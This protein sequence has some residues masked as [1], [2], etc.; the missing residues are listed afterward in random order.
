MLQVQAVRQTL[1][2]PRLLISL[3]C[4]VTVMGGLLTCAATAGPAGE[5][6]HCSRAMAREIC[7]IRA[8]LPP[9]GLLA[10]VAAASGDAGGAVRCSRA[11]KVR[12]MAAASQGASG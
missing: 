5:E 11:A 7:V 8:S 4:T 9:L 12:S 3:A 6:A 2:N 10:A 1:A